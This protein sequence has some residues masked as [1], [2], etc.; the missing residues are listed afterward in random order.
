MSRVVIPEEQ[1]KMENQEQQET[2]RQE[3][4]QQ[5][6][7]KVANSENGVTISSAELEQMF[8]EWDATGKNDLTVNDS[9]AGR[10]E[11]YLTYQETLKP[12]KVKLAEEQFERFLVSH[13]SDSYGMELYVNNEYFGKI[14]T[15]CKSAAYAYMPFEDFRM[16]LCACKNPYAYYPYKDQK[17][18]IDARGWV[19][20][21]GG[22]YSEENKNI[23]ITIPL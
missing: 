13:I 23:K 14:L 7:K 15:Y 5:V 16:V 6:V 20:E 4:E 8:Y 19:L 18:I 12:L 22:T 21:H 17:K 2:N 9:I 10:I 11:E 1:P 3:K